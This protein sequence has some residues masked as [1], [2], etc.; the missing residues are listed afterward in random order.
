MPE[1]L[2][3][4]QEPGTAEQQVDSEIVLGQVGGAIASAF[5]GEYEHHSGG[6]GAGGYY[7]FTSLAELDGIIA[8]VKAV[9]ETILTDGEKFQRAAE[10]AQPPAADIMSVM[11]AKA[12]QQWLIRAYEH[13]QMLLQVANAAIRKLETSRKLYASTEQGVTSDMNN[14]YEG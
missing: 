13:N 9:H 11:Q 5:D 10:L 3:Q 7:E 6:G 4:D 2:E 8:R 14:Q 12:T 1:G